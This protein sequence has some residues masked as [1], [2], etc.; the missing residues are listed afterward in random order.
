[1]TL[2]RITVLNVLR[3]MAAGV[4]TLRKWQRILQTQFNTD[5]KIAD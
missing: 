3:Y 2:K 5:V 1:M 4:M